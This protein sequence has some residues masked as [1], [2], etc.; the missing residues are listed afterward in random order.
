MIENASMYDLSLDF[1]RLFFHKYLEERDFAWL[2][3]H[4]HKNV[5]WIGTG[6]HEICHNYEDG[7]RMLEAEKES[8]NLRYQIV[9]DWYQPVSL[10]ED[11]FSVHGEISI[12]EDNTDAIPL[13]MN[14]RFSCIFVRAKDDFFLLHSHLS[15]ADAYQNDGEFTH[16]AIVDNYNRLL[17]QK[18]V[19][20]TELLRKKTHELETIT[21]N[22]CGGLELC[23]FDDR[24]TIRYINQ[25]FCD[26]TGYTADELLGGGHL[27]LIYPLDIKEVCLKCR[28]KLIMGESYTVQYRIVRKDGRIIWVLEN[29]SLLMAKSSGIQSVQCILTD[30]TVQ[31]EQAEAL[32][33]N[34]RRYQ[35]MMQLSEVVIFEYNIVTRELVFFNGANSIYG[36]PSVVSGGPEALIATGTIA[37]DTVAPYRKMYRDIRGGAP[38][39]Q[40]FIRVHSVDGAVYDF[41]LSLTT[42][43]DDEG[44][45]VYAIGIRKNVSEMMQ[46]QREEQFRKTLVSDKNYLYE[47]NITN[48]TF[49]YVDPDWYP[50]VTVAAGMPY[51]ATLK[52]IIP[53]VVAQEHQT[54]VR[55]SLSK[56]NIIRQLRIGNSKLSFDFIRLSKEGEL[57]WYHASV[58]I[59]RDSHSQS[60][61]IRL[62]LSDIHDRKDRELHAMEEQRLYESM[63]ARAIVAY[64]INLTRN[65]MISGQ[66]KWDVL[67]HINKSRCYS[68]M[69]VS[70]SHNGV[71]PEDCAQFERAVNREF[72]LQTYAQGQRE[73]TCQY[74]K[75]NEQGA[76]FWVCCTIHLYEDP[77]SCDVKGFVYVDDIDEQKRNELALRYSAEHD[78]MT[79]L[80][81]HGTTADL[82][83]TFLKTESGA[84]SYHA[85]LMIDIDSFKSINDNFG[86]LFGDEVLTAIAGEIRSTFRENDIVGRIGGDEFCVFMKDVP[87]H[88]TVLKKTEELRRKLLHTYTQDGK[89][90]SISASIGIAAYPEQGSSFAD[91]FK[92]ADEALYDAKRGGKNR[93]AL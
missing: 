85:F 67:Y 31:Q 33:L 73:V 90:A 6:A 39:A 51:Y 5:T 3:Q 75:L 62:Y 42:I 7:L 27:S 46:L 49:T 30:I 86:H 91:L 72:L 1:T 34:E 24:Y 47:V 64:E 26:M 9:R 13:E 20:R 15:I 41:K 44:K 58:N 10:G 78:R 4:L 60:L 2:A 81:N 87:Y 55:R 84:A 71:H 69:I 19:E 57:R 25:G 53:T 77:Q 16:R 83:D 88:R 18:L 12:I 61:L 37:P 8:S 92:H 79:G 54:L 40:C 68:D 35:T 63:I 56:R 65:L 29:G 14:V 22:I 74:R 45:P 23:D 38:S 17:E 32:R 76:Y 43:Y 50:G 82:V 48:D 52:K 93:Y 11:K 66:E 89:T 59:V 21:N 36:L 28:N 70:F 80:Y